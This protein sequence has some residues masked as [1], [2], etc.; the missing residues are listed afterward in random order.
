MKGLTGTLLLLLTLGQIF[1]QPKH[2]PLHDGEKMNGVDPFSFAP[3]LLLSHTIPN[4]FRKLPKNPIL[5]PTP[6]SWDSRDAADPFVLVTPDS[7]MM[8]YDGDN[9]DRYHIGYAVLDSLGWNWEKRGLL[10]S[11]SGNAWD[12]Y[13]Q[14]APVV[15]GES[16]GWRI[17]YNGHFEDEE[18]GYVWGLAEGRP[19]QIRYRGAR[20]LMAL[21]SLLWDF[22]GQN[23]GDILY[24]PHL[25]RYRMYYT[26][27]QGPL[28]G[29]GVA[30][31]RDG[32]SWTRV[33]TQPVIN[34]LPGV[35]APDVL[36]NGREYW[37]YFVTLY[38]NE[39]GRIAT[40]ICRTRSGDGLTWQEPEDV[41]IAGKKW[42]RNRLMRP[43][44]SYFQGRVQLFYCGGGGRWQ[45]GNAYANASFEGAGEWLSRL[46]EGRYREITLTF[47]KPLNTNLTVTLSDEAGKVV[48]TLDLEGEYRALRPGVKQIT[49]RRT[50]GEPFRIAM[51]LESSDPTRTP[52]VH[53]ISLGE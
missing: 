3:Q 13:H 22:G 36:Y 48:Q 25:Q 1:A 6:G 10:L 23:Y 34:R 16:D 17:Y 4:S 41:L 32:Y 53:S 15:L 37:M 45:I 29:I 35:I 14:I 12:S 21:D 11:G 18:I 33:G 30:E 2:I 9:D 24:L 20:P 28:A 50:T 38:L 43:H 44:L 5:S 49:V 8:F 47:E 51:R 39:R 52:V 40:K 42:E 7:I 31:S 19:G 46:Q 27:F 26:G